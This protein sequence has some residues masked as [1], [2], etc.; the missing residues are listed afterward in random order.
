MIKMSNTQIVYQINNSKLIKKVYEFHD[1]N[2]IFSNVKII[3]IHRLQN[4]EKKR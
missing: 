1:F 3:V 2:M 4:K